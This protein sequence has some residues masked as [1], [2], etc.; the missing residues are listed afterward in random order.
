[1]PGKTRAASYKASGTEMSDDLKSYL[2]HRF[3][4]LLVSLATKDDVKALKTDVASILA[5]LDEQQEKLN[6]LEETVAEQEQR[7]EK[8][9]SENEILKRHVDLLISGQDDHEQYSRRL[10]L[11]IDGMELPPPGE[12]ETSEQCLDKVLKIF[13]KMDVQIPNSV[14]DRA[15]RIGRPKKPK[16]PSGKVTQQIIIRFTIWRHKTMVYR[17]RKK[18]PKHIKFRLDL[19]KK[20]LNLLIQ[21]NEILK[22]HPNWFAFADVNCRTRVKIGDK[23][24]FFNSEEELTKLILAANNA[25]EDP[26]EEGEAGSTGEAE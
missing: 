2:D 10:C 3:D 5:R 13:E 25:P 4:Q 15:H 16:E 18:A 8:I 22:P 19:T 6:C 1:M 23:F 26:G 14:I 11:R 12:D 17:A 24:S 21:G 7:I 9:E 20:R